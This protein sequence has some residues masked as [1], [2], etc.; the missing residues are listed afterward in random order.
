M[1]DISP[2]DKYQ[3]SP[4]LR[5]VL[6]EF[7]PH[8]HIT[9]FPTISTDE[10]GTRGVIPEEDEFHF[11]S[12]IHPRHYRFFGLAACAVGTSLRVRDWGQ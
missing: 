5:F 9:N 11:H 7:V 1:P 4:N 12:A 8:Q 6:A 2:S 10:I 3:R